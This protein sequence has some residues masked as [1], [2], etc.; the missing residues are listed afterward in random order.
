MEFPTPAGPLRMQ[1]NEGGEEGWPWHEFLEILLEIRWL[2][3]IRISG[4]FRG[5]KMAPAEPL[6]GN[7]R[8]ISSSL[9]NLPTVASQRA[10]GAKIL[11]PNSQIMSK[12]EIFRVPLRF[13]GSGIETGIDIF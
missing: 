5:K 13:I 1:W 11:P 9:R 12:S 6:S 8:N 10:A 7:P 2:M 3:Q 4:N